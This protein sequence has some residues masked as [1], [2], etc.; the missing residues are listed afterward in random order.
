VVGGS[1]THCWGSI[2]RASRGE[3]TSD[4]RRKEDAVEM[5]LPVGALRVR[6]D[7]GSEEFVIITLYNRI[8]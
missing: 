7:F 4:R 3:K 6:V 1:S 5:K 2:L 8:L